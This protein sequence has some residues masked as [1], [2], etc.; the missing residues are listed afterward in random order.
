[1]SNNSTNKW[2]KS[3]IKQNEIDC[4]L[5]KGKKDF[6]NEEIISDKLLLNNNPGKQQIRDILQKSLAIERLDPSETAA[7]LHVN[8]PELLDEMYK[9]ALA[10]KQKVYD[11]RIVFFAPLYC[12]NLCVNNCAYCGF[13]KDNTEEKR[14]ILNTAEIK[15]EAES[16]IDEGHKRMIVVYGEHPASSIDYMIDSIET[17]YSVNRHGNSGIRRI[18]IN[19]APMSV[20]DLRRLK[21]VGIGTYQVFQETYHHD[22]YKRMHPSGP[23]S[24]YQWR[25]Y[26]LHRA[27]NAG[28][29]D[30]AIGALFGLYDWRFEVM[31]LLYHAIE[32][33]HQFGIGPHTISF[34]RLMPASGSDISKNSKYLVNDAD[35]K[36]IVTVLRLAIPYTGLIITA[37]EQA[38]LK[39]D[40]IRVGCTQ[41]DASTKIGVGGYSETMTKQNENKQQFMLGD[42]R[43]LDELIKELVQMDM[44]SSFCTAGYRCGRTGD[45]IMGLL[46][47]CVEGKFCKLN[48]VLTFKEYLEDYASEET[49]LTGEKLIAKEMSQIEEMPFYQEHNL[50]DKFNQY[51]KRISNGERDLYM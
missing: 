21:N 29:D 19:A 40:I 46:K 9:T 10:V 43:T 15:K 36:K 12:S 42:T 35:F 45:K 31:G 34:P 30:L 48:A 17:I 47:N 2:A 32:L 49:K 16:V 33:E 8:D 14:K 20:A 24:N 5:T 25:L 3:V 22:T 4:Y 37:R 41:T 38:D 39:R 13:R 6:I 44:I 7:L 50:I 18:N 27:M 28:I 23:K 1:M 26:A 51:Y 11:N